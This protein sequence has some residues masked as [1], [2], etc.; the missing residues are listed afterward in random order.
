[1]YEKKVAALGLRNSPLDPAT[2]LRRRVITV[3]DPRQ[4]EAAQQ[5]STKIQKH[6]PFLTL[7]SLLQPWKHPGS[8]IRLIFNGRLNITRRSMGSQP[9][10]VQTL[11]LMHPNPSSHAFPQKDVGKRVSSHGVS[12]TP[13]NAPD[14]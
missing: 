8:S 4:M 5:H 7:L 12:L 3:P 6:G 9:V 13:S 1:M 10:S 14:R 11:A 2:H